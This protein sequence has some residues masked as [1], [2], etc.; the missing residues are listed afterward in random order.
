MHRIFQTFIDRVSS[1]TNSDALRD[2]MS[3]AAAG[4]DLSC[5][6]YLSMPDKTGGQ[7]G[8]IS[9]YPSAWTTH[10]LQRHYE[11]FDPVIIQALGNPEPFEWGLGV[12]SIVPSKSLEL[13]EEA[14]RFG[15]P[16][17]ITRSTCS[18][19]FRRSEYTSANWPGVRN[20]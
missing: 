3:Q 6:V 18:F 8:L 9:N 7:A 4:L 5:F 11:R 17:S 19:E 14:A 16:Y 2:A 15:I 20:R 12:G 13:F 10:Y 1:A